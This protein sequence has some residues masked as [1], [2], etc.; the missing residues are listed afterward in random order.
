MLADLF[1]GVVGVQKNS[2]I[3]FPGAA[4]AVLFYEG[5]NLRCPYCHNVDLLQK[6]GEPVDADALLAFL[7]KRKGLL[8]GV[9]LSGGEPTLHGKR[10]LELVAFLQNELGYK[11]KVDSNGLHPAM[12]QELSAVDYLAVDLKCTPLKYQSEL[13]CAMDVAALLSESLAVVRERGERAEVRITMAPGVVEPED[14]ATLRDMVKGVE[15]L[16]LQRFSERHQVNDRDYFRT[17]SNY[18]LTELEVFAEAFRPFVGACI[19]R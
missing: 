11:V 19:V 15:N 18:T 6:G 8:D 4:S 5:C 13:G 14:I 2:F 1:S 16:Y 10:L 3:D 9:V 17:K 12:L 7:Q